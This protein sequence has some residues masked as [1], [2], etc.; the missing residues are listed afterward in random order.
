MKNMNMVKLAGVLLMVWCVLAT[1]CDEDNTTPAVGEITVTLEGNNAMAPATVTFSAVAD[2]APVI[3]WDFGYAQEVNDGDGPVPIGAV[4]QEVTM[5]FEEPGTY[6]VT[7]TAMASDKAKAK[8]TTVTVSVFSS[9]DL[10]YEL[11]EDKNTLSQAHDLCTD[12]V[13]STVN[14]ALSANI[15]NSFLLTE[16]YVTRT[17]HEQQVTDTVREDPFQWQ[18]TTYDDL[19]AG[20]TDVP[21]VLS[22]GEEVAITLSAMLH[23]DAA[24]IVEIGSAI[25]DNSLTEIY[26]GPVLPEGKWLAKNITSG[27]TS[28][29]YLVQ[30]GTN[31]FWVSDFGLDWSN[32]DDYWYTTEFSVTC[33]GDVVLDGEGRDNPTDFEIPAEVDASARTY[34]IR[35]MP[36]RALSGTAVYD[37][38]NKIISFTDV[39]V[40]DEWWGADN[41]TINLTFT[42]DE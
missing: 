30:T 9:D 4:G 24:T 1:A 39:A 15:E 17:W 3:L 34:G 18:A 25:V 27:F 22:N 37:A 14:V 28:D 31:T 7:V 33:D 38:V 2:E 29:V 16:Y 42:F 11:V 41:H 12:E 23:T 13:T 19:M 10:T 26:N 32:W 20:F 8:T 35:V 6:T 5:T 36:Y 40:T 21:T